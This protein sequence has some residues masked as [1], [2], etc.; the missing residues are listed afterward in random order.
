MQG[1]FPLALTAVILLASCSNSEMLIRKTNAHDAITEVNATGMVMRPIVAD[2]D[3]DAD[4][5]SYVYSGDVKL[6]MADLKQKAIAAFQVEHGCEYI[7]DATF[8]STRLLKRKV[9][10][11]ITIKVSGFP[12]QYTNMYQVDSLP[13]SIGQYAMLMKDEQRVNYLNEITVT[14]DV[15]G[16]EF[17]AGNYRGLQVDFPVIMGGLETRGFVAI[18]S[19]GEESMPGN[20]V[21]SMNSSTNADVY[22]A[23]GYIDEASSFA[24]GIMHQIPA[25]KKANFRLVG[26]LN[27]DSYGFS[28]ISEPGG[29]V[30][31]DS[32]A[33]I[34]LRLGGGMDVKIFR[35]LYGVGKL[36]KN[37]SLLRFVG[38][39]GE[40]DIDIADFEVEGTNNWNVGVGLRFVF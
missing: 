4:R 20:V 35:S 7:V 22:T 1:Q 30:S 24:F 9:V 26:G 29:S 38:K 2:L 12:A 16:F 37:V 31:F 11:E 6:P 5:K 18:E 34:G 25:S 27:I 14:E 8:E 32:A 10:Q 23:S 3:I 28:D 36:H 13:K 40:G 21:V 19:Y 39:D 33:L 15:I 17:S